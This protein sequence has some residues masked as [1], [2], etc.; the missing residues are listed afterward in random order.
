MTA[1]RDGVD[2]WAAYSSW[3]L[4]RADKMLLNQLGIDDLIYICNQSTLKKGAGG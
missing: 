3:L 2:I 1:Q 4:D